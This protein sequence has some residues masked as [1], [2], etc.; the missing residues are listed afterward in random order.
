MQ[1]VSSASSKHEGG[2][3]SEGSGASSASLEAKP[4]KMPA[5]TAVLSNPANSVFN[6]A[7]LGRVI[8]GEGMSIPGVDAT[9]AAGLLNVIGGGV[10]AVGGMRP[11]GVGGLAAAAAGVWPYSGMADGGSAGVAQL[12]SYYTAAQM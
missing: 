12:G 2:G 11:N 1:E 8:K 7:A 9:T 6:Q 4:P 3:Y 10:T 5:H